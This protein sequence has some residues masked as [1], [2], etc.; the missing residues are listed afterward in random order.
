[1]QPTVQTKE[2]KS[3]LNALPLEDGVTQVALGSNVW[4]GYA[5][6]RQ[7]TPRTAFVDFR[8][9]GAQKRLG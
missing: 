7:P 2:N 5:P 6:V 1:M 8:M 9:S 4:Q 3:V